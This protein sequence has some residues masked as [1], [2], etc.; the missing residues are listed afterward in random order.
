[1]CP[2]IPSRHRV[3]P[4]R[5][6]RTETL[7]LLP[8]PIRCLILMQG[9][10]LY[11]RFHPWSGST[12]GEKE[13]E[14]MSDKNAANISRFSGFA[15]CYDRY[16]PQP[17]IV[18]A[19]ILSQLAHTEFPRLVVDLGSGTR[20]STRM[21]I[22]HAQEVIG[23]EPNAD[24]RRA[25]EM[26]TKPGSGAALTYRDGHSTETGLADASADLVCCSQSFHWMEPQP[27]LVEA[28]RILR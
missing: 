21:W 8:N 14:A 12:I 6:A 10:R 1:M 23:I 26:R 20:L 25:A 15:D 17:P 13:V 24:M 18:I 28:A 22:G 4:P 5:P 11:V 7:R 19:E 16:R 9:C 3:Q 2:R 27:T